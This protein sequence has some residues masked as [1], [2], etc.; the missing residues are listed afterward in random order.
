MKNATMTLLLSGLLASMLVVLSGCQIE[1]A[2]PASRYVEVRGTGEVTAVPD[3]FQLRASFELTGQDV[4]TMKQQLDRQLAAALGEMNALGI[5]ERHIQASNLRVQPEWQWQPERKLIGQ[6]VSRD[7]DVTV[8]GFDTYAEALERLSALEVS[9]L[10]QSAALVRDLSDLQ[11]QALILAVAD[12]RHKAQ[13]LANAADRELG[14]ASII[15]EEGAQMPGPMPMRAMA[16]EAHSDG[17][18]YSAG[19]TTVQSR[20][21]IRFEIH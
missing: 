2:P 17:P 4:S 14:G 11:N 20:V 1:S 7:L 15:I 19:E 16:A 12:A 6:R 8:D 13:V 18:A 21:Q 5:D 3:R 9:A 10:H